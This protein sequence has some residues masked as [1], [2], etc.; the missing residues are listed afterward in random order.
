MWRIRIT[1]S[2]S[3]DNS[4]RRLCVATTIKAGIG[5]VGRFDSSDALASYS[6]PAKSVRQSGEE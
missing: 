5:E 1:T 3:E 2:D 4:L 6:D